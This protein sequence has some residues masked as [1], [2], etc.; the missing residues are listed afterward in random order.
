VFAGAVVTGATV[1]TSAAHAV[2][3][4]RLIDDA[5]AAAGLLPRGA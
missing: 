5:Y 1:P 2:T 4:M 3:T